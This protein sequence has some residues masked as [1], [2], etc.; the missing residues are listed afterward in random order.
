MQISS[1]IIHSLNGPKYS[2][3]NQALFQKNRIYVASKLS[4]NQLPSLY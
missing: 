1:A 3:I 4:T 2:S